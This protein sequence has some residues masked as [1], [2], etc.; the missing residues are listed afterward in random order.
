MMRHAM[1]TLNMV[2][3]LIYFIKTF[4]KCAFIAICKDNV[5]TNF[6]TPE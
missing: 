2:L 5:L 3:H 6:I 4:Y 1:V